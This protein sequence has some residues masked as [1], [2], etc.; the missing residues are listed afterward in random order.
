MVLKS[1]IYYQVSIFQATYYTSN[2]CAFLV[3]YDH[4]PPKSSKSASY[5]DHI[6]WRRNHINT[7]HKTQMPLIRKCTGSESLLTT[8]K[9]MNVTNMF[10]WWMAGE[11]WYEEECVSRQGHLSLTEEW[12]LSQVDKP[13]CEDYWLKRITFWLRVTSWMDSWTFCHYHSKVMR[14]CKTYRLLTMFNYPFLFSFDVGLWKKYRGSNKSW[15]HWQIRTYTVAGQ[16]RPISR[17][18]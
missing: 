16:S 14:S 2:S 6:H 11:W 8:A 12:S 3:R 4:L 10:L 13:L 17:T 9:L 5:I 7:L 18:K 15:T 1:E